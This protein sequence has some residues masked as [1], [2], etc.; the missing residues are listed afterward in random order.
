[1]PKYETLGYCPS[2]ELISNELFNQK[3]IRLYFE[4]SKLGDMIEYM[5]YEKK[6]S[7]SKV[8]SIVEVLLTRENISIEIMI[9]LKLNYQNIHYPEGKNIIWIVD[10]DNEL[11]FNQ[12]NNSKNYILIRDNLFL[13]RIENYGCTTKIYIYKK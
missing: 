8:S 4:R 9:S 7:R 6:S 3:E 2:N 11:D 13:V 10:M 12:I 5:V 1:M